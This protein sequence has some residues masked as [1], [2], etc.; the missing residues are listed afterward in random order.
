MSGPFR[1]LPPGLLEGKPF[2]GA[3]NMSSANCKTLYHMDVRL[4]H[5]TIHFSAA[6]NNPVSIYYL[7][8]EGADYETLLDS[9]LCSGTQDLVWRPPGKFCLE[10]DDDI[11]L[12]WTNDGGITYGAKVMALPI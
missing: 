8:K 5:L 1:E 12:V 6:T 4:L 3:G 2:T 10:K 7:P 11:Y 9:V